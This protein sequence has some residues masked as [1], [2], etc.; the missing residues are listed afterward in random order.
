[1]KRMVCGRREFKRD[2][3]TCNVG[4]LD[5][6]DVNLL[7]Y[8]PDSPI[9]PKLDQPMKRFRVNVPARDADHPGGQLQQVC[10]DP[11]GFFASEILT[12]FA[13]FV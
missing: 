7:D 9:L 8:P 5:L 12:I 13:F 6:M 1:M 10:L 3:L 11:M 2:S 4:M